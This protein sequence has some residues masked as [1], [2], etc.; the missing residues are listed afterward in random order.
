MS[1]LVLRG[2]APGSADLGRWN[3]NVV[4]LALAVVLAWGRFG[5]HAF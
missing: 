5:P 4:L 2:E 3:R 1:F